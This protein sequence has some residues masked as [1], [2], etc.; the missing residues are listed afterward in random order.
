MLVL[1]RARRK[2]K[3]NAL[4]FPRRYSCRVRSSLARGWRVPGRDHTHRLVS[5][6]AASTDLCITIYFLLFP[7][8]LAPDDPLV[9]P[10][11][12]RRGDAVPQRGNEYLVAVEL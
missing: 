7:G 12:P 4:F 8:L 1:D 10:Q 3:R 2:R 11:L 5:S 6:P 9:R